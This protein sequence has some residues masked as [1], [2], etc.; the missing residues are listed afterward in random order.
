MMWCM[1][2]YGGGLD[3]E[4]LFIECVCFDFLCLYWCIGVYGMVEVGV[5]VR[6]L[7]GDLGWL[8]GLEC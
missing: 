5:G 3:F 7:W 1:E 2:E 8:N 4:D 6:V